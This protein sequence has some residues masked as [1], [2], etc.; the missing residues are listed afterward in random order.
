[1]SQPVLKSNGAYLLAADL[2]GMDF[3]VIN[4]KTEKWKGKSEG[5]IINADINSKGYV[6]IL[7]KAKRYGGEAIIYDDFGIEQFKTFISDNSP[8]T[9]R[10]SP[11]SDM[12]EEVQLL[13]E[14][15]EVTKIDNIGMREY[16]SGTL[17]NREVVI[18]FSR[19]GKVAAA[20]TVTTLI[21][22]FN[23]DLVLFTGIAGAAD[24]KLNIGDIVIADKLIQ[25]A[26]SGSASY[27]TT[28]TG[29][30]YWN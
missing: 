12:Q 16:Y 6:A 10:I 4:G 26:A 15:V 8:V 29:N 19:W 5:E 11:N 30:R 1:M 7:S 25:H 17:Y 22:K 9:A 3:V 24:D 18:V 28:G 23:V 2:N 14:D 21:E 13:I 27:K 20:S